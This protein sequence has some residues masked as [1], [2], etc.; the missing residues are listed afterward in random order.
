VPTYDYACRSCGHEFEF[1]V[2]PGKTKDPACPECGAS[3][4]ERLLSRPMIQTE[5]TRGRA[6]RAAGRREAKRGE[7]RV[8]EQRRYEREH[9]GH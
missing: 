5:G 7:E 6:L 4:V 3:P 9:E 8:Q 2:L 1:L